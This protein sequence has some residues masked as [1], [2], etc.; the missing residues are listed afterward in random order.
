MRQHR[1]EL[2]P[3]R[4]HHARLNSHYHII[5]HEIP[6]EAVIYRRAL[7]CRRDSQ[8]NGA[9]PSAATA[10]PRTISGWETLQWGIAMSSTPCAPPRANMTACT[11]LGSPKLA[12]R[13]DPPF[14]TFRDKP[15]PNNR[16]EPIFT[17]TTV[18]YTHLRAHETDSYL[19]CRLLLE[20]KK[21]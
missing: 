20:K 19:V 11:K 14:R 15:G 8:I 12:S 3:Q 4:R 16:G 1:L 21:K 7:R 5:A 13:E 2:R 18:S 6:Y 17:M 9:A 10:V